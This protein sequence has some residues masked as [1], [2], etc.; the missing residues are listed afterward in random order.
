MRGPGRGGAGGGRT[1]CAWG[2]ASRRRR[3]RGLRGRGAEWGVGA[4]AGGVR[5]R[6][7]SLARIPIRSSLSPRAHAHL[8]TYATMSPNVTAIESE[9][10]WNTVLKES[11]KTHTPVRVCGAGRRGRGVIFL[12]GGL[13]ARASLSLTCAGAWAWRRMGLA[14]H[15]GSRPGSSV[16]YSMPGVGG[17]GT[18]DTAW[19]G[20]FAP[21][22]HSHRQTAADPQV[23]SLPGCWRPKTPPAKPGRLLHRARGACGAC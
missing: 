2:D 17:C 14:T 7:G 21:P 22:A 12:M 18:A 5:G 9:E 23:P 15:L 19:G 10:Q 3:W 20:F 4:R 1:A 13:A 11:K 6:G 16:N 8:C